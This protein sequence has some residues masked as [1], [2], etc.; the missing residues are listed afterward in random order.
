MPD[1]PEG[2][3]VCLPFVPYLLGTEEEDDAQSFIPTWAKIVRA[4]VGMFRTPT[5]RHS[6]SNVTNLEEALKTDWKQQKR[7]KYIYPEIT[8]EEEEEERDGAS[9]EG[10]YHYTFYGWDHGKLN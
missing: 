2:T 10:I 8:M 3:S 9:I 6:K 5:P 1:T 7:T 4:T